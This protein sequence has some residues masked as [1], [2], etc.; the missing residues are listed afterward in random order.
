M[1]NS[2]MIRIFL[3]LFVPSLV[4]AANNKPDIE[5]EAIKLTDSIYYVQGAAGIATDN[6]GF[7]SNAGFIV[8]AEGVVVFD[9]LGTPALA[10]K[11]VNVIHS[12]TDKPIK[13][14][15]LSHWH[16]DHAYGLQVFEDLG[17][18]IIG[19]SGALDY[20]EKDTAITRLNERKQSLAPWVSD[21]TRLVT[22][23][24]LLDDD[25]RFSLGSF[26]F[27]VSN[28]GAA[29][30]EGDL[31][32]LVEPGNVLFSG[33]V[34]YS[35]RIPFLGTANTTSWLSTLRKLEQ[36]SVGALVPGHGTAVANP[37]AIISFTRGYLEYVRNRMHYAIENWLPFAEVYEETDWSKYFEYPAFLEANRRNAYAVYLSLEAESLK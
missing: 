18:E 34:L 5:M 15:I 17:A 26:R 24:R 11:L 19:S 3:I 33:D 4:I 25:Y 14:V 37:A 35:E 32:L 20:L 2:M 28:L 31:T 30:S 36:K 22:P 1:N 7:I 27:T 10:N 8:T 16:A 23:D 6:A 13:T 9:S 12:I 21:T 29:H